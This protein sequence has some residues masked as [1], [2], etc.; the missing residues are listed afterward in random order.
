MFIVTRKYT[1][2]SE[3]IKFWKIP[4]EG[5]ELFN[6]RYKDK[7]L[8]RNRTLENNNLTMTIQTIWESKEAHAEYIADADFKIYFA[9]RNIYNQE[10]NIT[11]DGPPVTEEV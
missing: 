3:D 4:A 11:V 9:A 7:C 6:T 8:Y 1:R 5:A 10:N 2:P